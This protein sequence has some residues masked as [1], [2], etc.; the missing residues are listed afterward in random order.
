VPTLEQIGTQIKTWREQNAMFIGAVEKETALVMFLFCMIS[1]V[2]VVLILAIFW[3]MVAEKTKDI[4]ILRA[5]GASRAGVAWVWVRYGLAIGVVGG[6]LGGLTAF[7]IVHYINP[8]HEW[9]GS[10]LGIQI[11]DPRV[12]YFTT[13]PNKVNS[14]HAAIVMVGFVIA[15]GVGALVPAMRAAMLD[16]VRALR[17]E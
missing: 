13:I 1:A 8:I 5:M 9:M 12:Y 16:P 4:G 17:F 3:S 11:W 14:M 10:V 2:A 6:L 7:L 15:S